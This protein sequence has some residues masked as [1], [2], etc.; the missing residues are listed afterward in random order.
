MMTARRACAALTALCCISVNLACDN[1]SRSSTSRSPTAV[2]PITSGTLSGVIFEVTS[3]SNVP[4]E[5]VE[6]YCDACGGGHAASFSDGE[7]NYSFTLVQPREYPLYVSKPGYNLA[8]P[9][10]PRAG[11]WMGF[12]TVRVDG[13]TRFDIELVRH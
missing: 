9:S 3:D 7:G 5:G 2:T 13:D 4:V 12:I 10:G 11:G 6:V 1:T 8:K